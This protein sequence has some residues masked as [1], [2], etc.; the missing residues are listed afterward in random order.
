[1]IVV[2]PEDV[3]QADVGAA[4]I[5]QPTLAPAVQVDRARIGEAAALVD[6]AER[7]LVVAGEIVKAEGARTQL[8]AFAE[9][10]AA[11]VV[12]AFRCQ[13]VLDNDHPAYGGTFGIGRPAYLDQAWR[14]ADL[15][16]LA[17]SRFDAISS[18]DFSLRDDAKTRLILHPDPGTVAE[19]GPGLGLAGA[20]G[21]AL[22][23]I[24]DALEPPGAARRNWQTGQRRKYEE[25]QA[26][27]PDSVGA[28][29]MTQVV[30]HVDAR[31]AR[32]DHVVTNDA[33]N[34]ATWLQRH[35]RY[36]RADSQA[37]PMSGAMGYGVPGAVGATMA[38]AGAR[39][40]AFVGDGGFM[41]TGQ[42]LATA[43]QNRLPI[44]V[45]VCDNRHYGTILMHQH[46]YAGAGNHT[47]VELNSPDFAAV[48]RAFGAR[49]WRVAST[50][51]FAPAF[52]EALAHDGPG[53][54]HVV[55]DIRDISANGPLGA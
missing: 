41:M 22:G 50:E 3:T 2:L 38:R 14:E 46:R 52:D 19:L 18:V 55:T 32:I 44:V 20:V 30:R 8:Q 12:S 36:R 25:F 4:A 17:G 26:Q 9:A 15:V 53:L 1:M 31:L 54:I 16:V 6:A 34:F 39:V 33:G 28:V 21:P 49:S 5:P 23:A 35:Y 42:E 47:A 24:A 37:A 40:V 10:S 29:D 27:P 11:A 43:V 7:V 48:A 51:A 45:V 13:D